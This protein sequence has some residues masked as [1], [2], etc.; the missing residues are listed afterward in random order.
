MFKSGFQKVA[1]P[2]F[3]DEISINL[4]APYL[5]LTHGALAVPLIGAL[6]FVLTVSMYFFTAFTDPG[7]VPRSTP[8][9]TIQTE[10]ENGITVD[11]SGA[12]YPTPKLKVIDL[13]GVDY[14]SKFCTTCKFYRPPRT[15]HCSTCNMCVER[16]DHHCPFVSNCVG[17]RNYRYF[18]LFL[19]FGALLG[20]YGI[21]ASAAAFGLRI[22]D[23][24]PVGEAFKNSVVSIIVGVYSFFLGLNLVGMAGAHT[25]YTCFEKT[26][27]ERIKSR[28]KTRTGEM[29]NPFAQKNMFKN[30]V[31][32]ICGPTKPKAID[33]RIELPENYYTSM[34][35]RTKELRMIHNKTTKNF[36]PIPSVYFFKETLKKYSKD[37]E[38]F[39]EEFEF[40][41]ASYL[42]PKREN[43]IAD[44]VVSETNSDGHLTNELLKN[45]KI[46]FLYLVVII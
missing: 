29:I 24:Q 43:Y 38:E 17:A 12:Y 20:I 22:R 1:S 21:A 31:Y 44:L 42:K 41:T 40:L 15:V 34:E 28:F 3:F 18:Y 32:V 46:E 7:F 16:F 27:N 14:D 45:D 2:N 39:R 37:C 8:E 36:I 26:T 13:K 11:L 35:V 4:S 10:K 25:S 6:I 5:A 9:E 30:F 23:I 19:V 33:Y